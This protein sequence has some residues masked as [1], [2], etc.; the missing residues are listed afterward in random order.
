[1]ASTSVAGRVFTRVQWRQ[2]WSR[3]TVCWPCLETL[4]RWCDKLA[5]WAGQLHNLFRPSRWEIV[6][7]TTSFFIYLYD[8]NMFRTSLLRLTHL[9]LLTNILE[10]LVITWSV[11]NFRVRR[12][13]SK[14]LSCNVAYCRLPRHWPTPPPAWW[15]LPVCVPAPPMRCPTRTPC[16]MQQRRSELPPQQQQPQQW[17]PVPS[18]D[19]RCVLEC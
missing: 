6:L 8:Q 10:V 17:G 14:T 7:K 13:S 16:V 1:M 5:S 12:S 11:S 4:G 9:K 2:S 3:Q 19:S 18:L 15:R